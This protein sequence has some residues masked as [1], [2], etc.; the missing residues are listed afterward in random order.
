MNAIQ[1][2]GNVSVNSNYNKT[3][4]SPNFK[5]LHIHKDPG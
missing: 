5:A 2:Y 4:I 1:N 3:N